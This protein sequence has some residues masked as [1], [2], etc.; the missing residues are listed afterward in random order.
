MHMIGF[1]FEMHEWRKPLQEARALFKK[2]ST[3]PAGPEKEALVRKHNELL[4][5]AGRNL[6]QKDNEFNK[7]NSD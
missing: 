1:D 2:I 4:E 3:M 7:E 6:D 5:Q